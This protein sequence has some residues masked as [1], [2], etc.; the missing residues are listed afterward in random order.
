[1]SGR[2]ALAQDVPYEKYTLPNGMTVILHEDHALPVA[3]V[4]LWY[5]VGSKDEQPG[6]SGFAHLFEHL[7]FMGTQR[8]PGLDFDRLME[9]GGGWNNATTSEDRTN[10]FSMGPAEL[11]PTLLWLDA[12]RL[13]ALGANM[14]QEKL[15]KQRDVVRN[16]RRQ[17][18]ENV[19][20]GKA[21]LEIYK[22]MY[23]RDHAYWGTVIGSHEDLEAA[24][25]D[26]VKNF[27][28]TYYVP[29]NAALV[30]AGDFDSARVKP[31]IDQLFGTLPRGSDV[32]HAQARPAKLSE[33]KRITMTD[34]VQYPR[35][36]MVYH[37]PARFA[38]GDAEMDLA[39]AVLSSG[40]SSRLYQRLIYKD[41]LAT[42]VSAAQSSMLLGSMFTIQATAQPGVDLETIE[43]AIDDTVQTFLKQGPTSEELERQKVQ[44]EYDMLT[45]LQSVLAKADRLNLYEF[46]F[47]EPNS[48]VRDLE[49]YRKATPEDVRREAEA[50]LTPDARLILRVIPEIK[51]PAGN[52]RDAAPEAVAGRAFDPLL[53]VTFQLA[54]GMTVHHWRRSELPL[55][56]AR[57][58]LRNGA[59]GEPAGKAGLA[60]LTAEM[61]DEG[62][63][64]LGAVDFAKALE[65]LGA[66]L[67]TGVGRETTIVEL[68]ALA[69]NFE[70]ALAL[71]AD[72]VRRPRFEDR[73]W[74]R[75][76][77]LHVEGLK[78]DLD[79]P[80]IVASRVAMRAFFGDDHPYGRPTVGT[81]DSA[82]GLTLADITGWH[83]QCYRPSQAVLLVAGDI[84][85]D[86]L[87]ARLDK[88]FGDWTDP[89]G[90]APP[91][92]PQLAAPAH[93]GLD[94]IIVDR[95]DA[96]QTV[97]QF[98]MPAP[99]YGD[100]RRID[101]DLLG[102][103]LGGT[104]TSRLNRNLREDKGYTYGARCG[105][106][107]DRALGYFTAGA[108]VRADVTGASLAEFLKEFSSL[109][110]GN[111]SP[112]EGGKARAARRMDLMESFAGLEGILSSATALI[113]NDRPFSGL[114]E[115][116]Q[117]M[118][119]A[120]PEQLNRQAYDAV[121]LEKGLLVLLGDKDVIR[122][123]LAGLELPPPRELTVTG[124][125]IAAD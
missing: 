121:P 97:V 54:N 60:E 62:A 8:V 103:I 102:T 70:P 98:I 73:E 117:L 30:V 91:A 3:C 85:P 45:S 77:D 16:E 84:A 25:V 63:G 111:V 27:F 47:G 81:V 68:T 65:A 31:L 116:L 5:R 64:T 41:E 115:D 28:A 44:I 108:R 106:A 40:I 58:L 94:V 10:Y 120:S 88:A 76:Q 20:Y 6:R 34:D 1:V 100:P 12:D 96:V 24:T 11:L 35:T 78:Q 113:I 7:M 38:P 110:S 80:G 33:V 42:E 119:K 17:S 109:R 39:A 53:P 61:L 57:L 118:N 55:I 19:P 99:P 93:K 56:S 125:P 4:N 86:Q 2:P 123:Q 105:Y 43:M 51:E 101:L 21:E 32:V 66:E 72:A 22:L 69:R 122:A 48:F 124:D 95:P 50:V 114:A 59:A 46:H 23:P 9:A 36:Y 49:R 90:S 14:T 79:E 67:D 29:S 92:A 75:V 83:R 13:E 37:S 89:S 87:R 18:I 52:P 71:L 74:K 82:A 112:E 15:D 107:M 104:F 26:D